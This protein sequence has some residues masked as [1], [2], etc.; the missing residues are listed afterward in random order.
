MSGVLACVGAGT[1]A[2]TPIGVFILA[3]LP[4]AVLTRLI[5]ITLLA[6][7]GLE[8]LGFYPE[9]LAGRRWAIGAGVAAGVAL[10][11]IARRRAV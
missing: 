1:V 2:G 8:W 7:V 4:I 9:R 5:G 10:Y 6:I 11:E 3:V